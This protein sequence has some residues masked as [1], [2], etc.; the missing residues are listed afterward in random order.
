MMTAWPKD[1]KEF[2]VSVIRNKDRRTSYSYIP[3]PILKV[4]GNP[5]H[6]KFIIRDGYVEVSLTSNVA[7]ARIWRRTHRSKD[8]YNLHLDLHTWQQNKLRG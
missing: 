3:K 1:A 8:Y 2:A 4:L 7:G 5:A 6:L